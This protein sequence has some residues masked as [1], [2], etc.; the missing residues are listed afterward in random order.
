MAEPNAPISLKMDLTHFKNDTLKEIKSLE[1]NL[2]ENFRKS[3]IT[4]QKKLE[5]FEKKLSEYN[6]KMS[7]MEATMIESH[8]T[9]EKMDIMIQFKEKT[10]NSMTSTELR[11]KNLEKEQQD[12]LYN[13]SNFLQENILYPGLIGTTG[14]YKT[15]HN[16]ID[17]VLQQLSKDD[18]FREEMTVD[19]ANF[20]S[21]HETFTV[22][23]R[24]QFGGLYE[25]VMNFIKEDIEESLKSYDDK[26]QDILK[27]YKDKL[28]HMK[29][30]YDKY[31][32]QNN[33]ILIEF[34]KQMKKFFDKQ[35]DLFEKFE[36]INKKSTFNNTEIVS[37][38]DQCKSIITGIKDAGL[39]N[40]RGQKIKFNF[41]E[42]NNN[43]N[44]NNNNKQFR[45][46]SPKKT[47]YFFN[48]E[49]SSR[50]QKL[51]T[52]RSIDNKSGKEISKLYNKNS[53]SKKPT[54]NYE[55][56]LIGNN[57]IFE[58]KNGDL[59]KDKSE[60]EQ[61]SLQTDNWEFN[62]TKLLTEQNNLTSNDNIIN[63]NNINNRSV[64]NNNYNYNH[65]NYN[66]PY[67]SNFEIGEISNDKL[68]IENYTEQNLKKNGKVKSINSHNI[69]NSNIDYKHYKDNKDNKNN[70]DNIDN[71][72][73][74][75]NT[76]YK[77]K[78]KFTQ[79]TTPKNNYI[80]SA[81]VKKNNNVN[82]SVKKS[83][84]LLSQPLD[85]ISINIDGKDR[86]EINPRKAK[87]NTK[88]Q[89]L[90]YSLNNIIYDNDFNK[91]NNTLL[92]NNSGYPRIISNHGQQI[93]IST[94]PMFNSNKFCRY[95]NPRLNELDRNIKNLYE[96]FKVNDQASLKKNSFEAMKKTEGI[97]F[98]EGGDKK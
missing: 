56:P 82:F 53:S 86:L 22:Q 74:N 62:I 42:E 76:I 46:S 14:K 94:K 1:K 61:K 52:E 90:L 41:G 87:S 84:C 34:K 38:K 29:K 23:T 96:N 36:D 85:K 47:R 81:S 35:N 95:K 5:T 89:N 3:D 64:I 31:F 55:K 79:N 13:M 54:K 60:Y 24:E 50:K 71:I 45:I 75:D 26:I 88:M 15:F 21:K 77:L 51:K 16:F 9:K 93:I 58:K 33:N 19:Y 66:K 57:R 28:S 67:I 6:E 2:A 27:E 10:E 17:Y 12:T 40:E 4:L 20:K 63:D 43:N 80:N 72:D 44:N 39:K 49:Q 37:I 98:I 32:M 48:R 92:M 25:K 91:K 78:G 83:K 7:K 69:S 59:F 73:N 97:L 30:D 65:Y 18:K 8:D 70:I 11:L 68:K